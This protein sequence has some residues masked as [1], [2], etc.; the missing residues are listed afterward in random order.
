MMSHLQA[1]T[2][3]HNISSN[4]CE[5]Q[6]A[7]EIKH[8]AYL[9]TTLDSATSVVL[10]HF[11]PLRKKNIYIWLYYKLFNFAATFRLPIANIEFNV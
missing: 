7:N 5:L 1:W 3:Q 8:L 4:G 10:A 11:L 2:L 6:I 9:Y